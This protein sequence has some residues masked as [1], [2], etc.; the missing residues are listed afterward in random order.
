MTGV[1]A[2]SVARLLAA[3]VDFQTRLRAT[4]INGIASQIAWIN[5][6]RGRASGDLVIVLHS[7][8]GSVRCKR[9]GSQRS[10]EPPD[11]VI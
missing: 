8:T 7:G 5:G 2:T 9:D 6:D 3:F 11:D 4:D 10:P 1:H